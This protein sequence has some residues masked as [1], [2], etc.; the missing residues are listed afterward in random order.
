MTAQTFAD[1]AVSMNDT[2][3]CLNKI[4]AFRDRSRDASAVIDGRVHHHQVY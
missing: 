4:V 3:M 1:Q 2:H